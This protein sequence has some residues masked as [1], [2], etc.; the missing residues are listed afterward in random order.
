MS[1]PSND[2]WV[3]LLLRLVPG[4][5]RTQ[6]RGELQAERADMRERGWPSWRVNVVTIGI[7][8]AGIAQHVPLSRIDANAAAQPE[9]ADRAALVGWILWRICGPL[10]FLGY[11]LGSWMLALFGG[12][13]L[14]GAFG[15]I[16]AVV[17]KGREP[18][19]NTE[20]R[21]LNGVFGGIVAVLVTSMVFGAMFSLLLLLGIAVGSTGLGAFAVKAL[22]FMIL[23][24]VGAMCI[25]GWVPREWEPARMVRH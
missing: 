17:A 5:I 3:G 13:A 16:G 20:A 10:L 1:K 25:V 19:D 2:R 14:V 12:L 8:F 24:F 18:Y 15:C 23:L 7:V 11:A 4:D 21:L 22:V 6:F 9:V